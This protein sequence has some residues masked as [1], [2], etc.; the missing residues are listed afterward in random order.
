MNAVKER[1]ERY[2]GTSFSKSDSWRRDVTVGDVT[3]FPV[4]RRVDGEQRFD[5]VHVIALDVTGKYLW[6]FFPP[7]IA[8]ERNA[9]LMSVWVH[10]NGEDFAVSDCDDYRYILDA[11]TGAI[12]QINYSMRGW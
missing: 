12:K 4:Y 11:K 6:S 10:E 3:A 8:E 2:M 7:G 9:G 1:C 5:G